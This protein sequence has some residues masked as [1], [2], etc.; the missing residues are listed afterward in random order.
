[1]LVP[2][3]EPYRVRWRSWWRGRRFRSIEGVGEGG[4]R[5]EGKRERLEVG[6]V[7]ELNFVEAFESDFESLGAGGFG[8]VRWLK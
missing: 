1:M 4:A 5:G 7:L 2:A 6:V 3:V 8:L